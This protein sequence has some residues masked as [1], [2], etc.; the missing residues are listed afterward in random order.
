MVAEPAK[1]VCQRRRSQEAVNSLNQRIVSL[2]HPIPAFVKSRRQ[3]DRAFRI[4]VI[5]LSLVFIVHQLR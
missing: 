4:A 5:R 2:G 3:L 1:E